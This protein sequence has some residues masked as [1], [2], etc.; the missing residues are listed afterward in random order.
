VGGEEERSTLLANKRISDNT[1]IISSL[2][3]G[4]KWCRYRLIIEQKYIFVGEHFF[5][6]EH[7]GLY[8]YVLCSFGAA[9][10][11]RAR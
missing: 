5:L 4:F 8:L 6:P 1:K 9:R 3:Q 7:M 11:I 2:L 10:H